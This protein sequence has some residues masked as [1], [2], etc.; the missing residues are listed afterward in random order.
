MHSRTHTHARTSRYPH[1]KFRVASG[2]VTSIT[3]PA[4]R[5]LQFFGVAHGETVPEVQPS[6]QM[7]RMLANGTPQGY[8]PKAEEEDQF[9]EDQQGGQSRKV[10]H[11]GRTNEGSLKSSKA[12]DVSRDYR[13]DREASGVEVQGARHEDAFRCQGTVVL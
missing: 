7:L 8:V 4:A 1:D 9:H 2:F 13:V 3:L 5:D 12:N 6:P 10:F 11:R